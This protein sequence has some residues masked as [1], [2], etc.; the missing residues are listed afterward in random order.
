VVE[1]VLDAVDAVD[2]KVVVRVVVKVAVR[3]AETVNVDV[4]DAEDVADVVDAPDVTTR[5]RL[6]LGSP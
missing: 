2:V 6:A 4:E 5:R 1:E 3:V